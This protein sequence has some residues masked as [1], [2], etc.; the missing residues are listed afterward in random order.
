MAR[1]AIWLLAAGVI[2]NL[3]HA[4]PL[5]EPVANAHPGDELF[6]GLRKHLDLLPVQGSPT[7]VGLHTLIDGAQI[8]LRRMTRSLLMHLASISWDA[9]NQ[10]SPVEKTFPDWFQ[11]Y[12]FR[13]QAIP[14][15]VDPWIDVTFYTAQVSPNSV[16]HSLANLGQEYGI[17]PIIAVVKA[18]IGVVNSPDL[19]VNFQT[20]VRTAAP[21]HLDEQGVDSADRTSTAIDQALPTDFRAFMLQFWLEVVGNDKTEQLHYFLSNLLA[22]DVIPRIIGQQL[23]SHRH[24]EALTLALRISQ[25]PDFIKMIEPFSTNAPNYFEFIVMYATERKLNRFPGLVRLAQ[26]LGNVDVQSIFNCFAYPKPEFPWTALELMFQLERSSDNR[27]QLQR[28]PVQCTPLSSKYK[29]SLFI[30]STPVVFVTTVSDEDW[31][32]LYV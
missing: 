15:F 20:I 3:A 8:E 2:A 25:Y 32:D 5:V 24:A 1:I 31:S 19:L 6:T 4:A 9:N 12:T 17:N 7:A 22:F 16:K 18:L 13:D 28:A 26:R 30:N 10:P 14:Q 29:R 27:K 11:K 21:V 23:E